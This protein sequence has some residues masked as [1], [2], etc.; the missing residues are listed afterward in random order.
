MVKSTIT[1]AVLLILLLRSPISLA[2]R[3][4]LSDNVWNNYQDSQ[5]TIQQKIYLHLTHPNIHNNNNLTS[6]PAKLLPRTNFNLKLLSLN[7]N[8]KLQPHP[9]H[10]VLLITS[11]K[12]LF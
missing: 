1:L 4:T 11:F 9:L 6:Q 10:P 8:P 7:L 5:T 3:T 2:H 12:N